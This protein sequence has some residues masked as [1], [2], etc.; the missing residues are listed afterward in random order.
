MAFAAVSPLGG[1]VG[2]PDPHGAE[3]LPQPDEASHVPLAIWNRLVL[4]EASSSLLHVFSNNWKFL[5]LDHFD[6]WARQ[7]A[8]SVGRGP[9]R[10][11]R[12]DAPVPFRAPRWGAWLR[13]PRGPLALSQSPQPSCSQRGRGGGAGPS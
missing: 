3:S 1:L 4:K 7:E 12:P 11:C 9:V 10:P 6:S 5:T 8:S 13:S 2:P